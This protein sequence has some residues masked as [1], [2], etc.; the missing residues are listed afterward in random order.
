MVIL[1]LRHKTVIVFIK[2]VIQ[3]QA[4]VITIWQV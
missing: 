4:C 1:L 3:G 2:A